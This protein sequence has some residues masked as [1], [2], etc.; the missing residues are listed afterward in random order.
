MKQPSKETSLVR[1]VFKQKN[2]NQKKKKSMPG[3]DMSAL[4][5]IEKSK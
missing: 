4:H 1:L 5:L 2:N 3:F